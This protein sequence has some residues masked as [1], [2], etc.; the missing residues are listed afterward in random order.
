MGFPL[1]RPPGFLFHSPLSP[2]RAARPGVLTRS[3]SQELVPWPLVV[4][5]VNGYYHALGVGFLATRRQ[6]LLAY[7]AKGGQ[8]NERL[9][10]VFAQLL[11]PRIRRRYDACPLGS[12]F[13]DKYIAE[14]IE[15][16]ARVIALARRVSEAVTV[17]DVLR[18]WG[19][20]DEKM[21]AEGGEE[22]VDIPTNPRNDEGVAEEEHDTWPYTFYLW[23]SISLSHADQVSVMR[24]WQEH[25][26]EACQQRGVKTS[27]G[28]GL[29]K[30][31]VAPSRTLSLSL[32]D[33]TVLFIADDEIHDIPRLA[34]HAVD[35]FLI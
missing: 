14:E 1:D 12:F 11:N 33:V 27:F 19:F 23:R 6:L 7:L 18:E 32:E 17:D 15:A 20:D 4:W 25:L 26:V 22:G 35:T 28:V 30:A 3:T 21:N 2:H 8:E 29:M 10:Y 9:T 13:M 34:I 16:R 31:S 5:D 24:E